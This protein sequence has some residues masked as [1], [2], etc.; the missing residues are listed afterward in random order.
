MANK[1]RKVE[2]ETLRE[3]RYFGFGGK[4]ILLVVQKWGVEL[5]LKGN[6]LK[7]DLVV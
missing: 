1:I 4:N 7:I 5:K 6:A 2:K 3:S